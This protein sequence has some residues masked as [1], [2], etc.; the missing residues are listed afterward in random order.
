MINGD[1]RNGNNTLS[2]DEELSL[3]VSFNGHLSLLVV[4]THQ[5]DPVDEGRT[6]SASTAK[7]VA[8]QRRGQLDAP[9]ED[10]V[11]PLR[12]HQLR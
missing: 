11:K 8:L 1:F 4:P 2:S 10:A 3:A 12:S 7:H 9:Q 5:K 6:A